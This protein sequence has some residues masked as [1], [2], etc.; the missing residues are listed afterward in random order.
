[1][2]LS[3][4]FCTILL[5]DLLR[6]CATATVTPTGG[7]TGSVTATSKNK[8]SA[9]DKMNSK[10]LSFCEDRGFKGY[11]LRYIRVKE[12]LIGASAESAY[13]DRSNSRS[14]RGYR[15]GRGSRSSSGNSS[16]SIRDDYEYYY[17]A[18]VI[19]TQRK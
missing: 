13:N 3:L 14:R 4:V 16:A 15:S 12:R 2:K 19:C 17:T 18:N 5:V 6:F 8:E 10:A 11:Y 9:A 7:S 1:M